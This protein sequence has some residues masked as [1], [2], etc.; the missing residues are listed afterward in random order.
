MIGAYNTFFGYLSFA[1]LYLVFKGRLHYLVILVAAH[2]LAVTNA[3]VGHKFLTFRA[4]GYLWA[5]FLRFN[6]TYLGALAFGLLGLPF[7][8]EVCKFHPLISQA[9]L[10]AIS[11]FGTY[12]LHRRVSF[13]RV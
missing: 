12:V 10:M 2:I 1:G 4:K 11:M 9:M 6:L 7:L 13:R 3:F 5:D 8:I